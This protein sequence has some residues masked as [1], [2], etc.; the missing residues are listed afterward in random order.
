MNSESLNGKN[1]ILWKANQISLHFLL[2]FVQNLSNI[3]HWPGNQHLVF[4][5]QIIPQESSCCLALLS[6]LQEKAE[7]GY[8][9]YWCGFLFG[10][11]ESFF[12]TM[13]TLSHDEHYINHICM[14]NVHIHKMVKRVFF[15]KLLFG[16][17]LCLFEQALA[18]QSKPDG[19][20]FS[21]TQIQQEY[22]RIEMSWFIGN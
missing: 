13:L 19:P 9:R 4:T 10:L 1:L 12:L 5:K 20:S 16:T 8:Q 11:G 2:I 22:V 3:C 17:Q 15:L 6:M 14:L 18:C 7:I 21:Y